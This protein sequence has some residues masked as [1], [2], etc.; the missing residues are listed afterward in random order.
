MQSY[1]KT[2]NSFAYT[3]QECMTSGWFITQKTQVNM[4]KF[5]AKYEKKFSGY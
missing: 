2:Y 3:S 5:V 1:L 4:L